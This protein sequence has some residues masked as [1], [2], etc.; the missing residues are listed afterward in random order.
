[1][2]QAPTKLRL[3]GKK[4]F[5]SLPSFWV[6]RFGRRASDMHG[7][8]MRRDRILFYGGPNT[9]FLFFNNNFVFSVASHAE[10]HTWSIYM[11]T[12]FCKDYKIKSYN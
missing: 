11:Y 7:E 6:T 12:S 8:E 10:V 3:A 4:V 9:S 2:G 1:M 5:F